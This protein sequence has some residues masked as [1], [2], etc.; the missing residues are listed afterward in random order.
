MS[1]RTSAPAVTACRDCGRPIRFMHSNAAK[2]R[3]PVE[4]E[5]TRVLT[6]TGES[7]LGH[8]DHRK[9]CPKQHEMKNARAEMRD[10]AGAAAEEELEE[11]EHQLALALKARPEAPLEVI[12]EAINLEKHPGLR[13]VLADLLGPKRSVILEP[14][15]PT[16]VRQ[17]ATWKALHIGRWPLLAELSYQQVPPRMRLALR[18]EIRQLIEERGGAR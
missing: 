9:V 5:E 18:P 1:P 14:K 6:A 4:P 11:R 13:P 3:V 16:E 7:V 2:M 17:I 8:A 12:G 10:R 15:S